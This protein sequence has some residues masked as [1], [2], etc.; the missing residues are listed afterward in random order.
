M[1]QADVR[2]HTGSSPA[3]IL[4]IQLGPKLLS[5]SVDAE[6]PQ[7]WYS[8]RVAAV[9]GAGATATFDIAFDDGDNAERI[10]RNDV[11]VAQ[12]DVMAVAFEG[13]QPRLSC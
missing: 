2:W 9:H 7:G 6:V 4:D 5:L 1:L 11:E 3:V 13:E 10:P 8:G 12:F